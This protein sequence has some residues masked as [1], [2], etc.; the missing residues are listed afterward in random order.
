MTEV[1]SV[2]VQHFVN[3]ADEWITGH[4][5]DIVGVED[6]VKK[7]F[8]NLKSIRAVLEKSSGSQENDPFLGDRLKKLESVAIDAQD[9]LDTYE[10]E[11]ALWNTCK[12]TSRLRKYSF[13]SKLAKKI[14]DISKTLDTIKQEN[15][16]P[17]TS[18]DHGG[19]SKRRQTS[20]KEQEFRESGPSSTTGQ[21]DFIGRKGVIDRLITQIISEMHFEGTPIHVVPIIGISGVGKTTLAQQIYNDE[22][23][24]QHFGKA[25]KWANITIDFNYEKFVEDLNS[26]LKERDGSDVDRGYFLLVLDDI[27][28]DIRNDHWVPLEKLLKQNCKKSILLFTTRNSELA[29]KILGEEPL[30]ESYLPVLPDKD[31]MELF[32]RVAFPNGLPTTLEKKYA[33][34][35]I[36]KCNG[37][38]LAVKAIAWVLRGNTK[39]ER[40]WESILKSDIWKLEQGP[41]S[42]GRPNI[43][44]ALRLGYNHLHRIIKQCFAYCSIFPKGYAFQKEELVKLWIAQGYIDPSGSQNY[45]ETGEDYFDELVATSFFQ[46][47]HS[48]DDKVRYRLHDLMLEMA[49]SV[50]SRQCCQIKDRKSCHFSINDQSLH[51]SLLCEDVEKLVEDIVKKS[52]RLRT[53]LLPS[54]S[55]SIKNFGKA[56]DKLFKTLKYIRVLDLS[57]SNLEELPES[58]KK[59]K[60]LRYLDLSNTKIRV[61]PDSICNLY[62]LQTLKLLGC[63]FWNCPRTSGSWLTCAILS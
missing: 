45:E 56:F 26:F 52:K 16:Y 59:L 33:W 51:V 43:L 49:Q 41:S 5:K 44:P 40:K 25:R 2:L 1:V 13:K 30:Q 29:T 21:D 7:I 11:V 50:S 47:V 48:D 61:L 35:I 31:C 39:D 14:K 23:I 53:L 46:V 10:T 3:H 19:S 22:A 55:G 18:E 4:I 34:E 54:S 32:R 12:K 57:S 37:L 60:L 63:G 42:S 62:N 15:E 27:I 58:V 17:N 20:K 28:Q 24:A 38:P 36:K 6:E 9:V 8:S